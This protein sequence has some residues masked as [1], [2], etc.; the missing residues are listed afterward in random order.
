MRR[1]VPIVLVLLTAAPQAALAG[2][3]FRCRYTGETRPTCCC[4]GSAHTSSGPAEPEVRRT[5]CCE[6]LH[7]EPR[8]DSAS[9]EALG[10]LRAPIGQFA[11]LPVAACSIAAGVAGSHS[12]SPTE[13]RLPPLGRG[14]PLYLALSSLLL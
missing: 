7:N 9:A 5:T 2:D 3:W 12:S 1:L 10:E 4:G 11:V 13:L 14:Q 8:A 6:L